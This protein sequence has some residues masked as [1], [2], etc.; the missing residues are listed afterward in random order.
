MKKDIYLKVIL[1]IIAICLVWICMRDI[2]IGPTKL[3]ASQISSMFPQEVVIVGVKFSSYKTPDPLPIKNV[4]PNSLKVEVENF[5][6]IQLVEVV[7]G[8]GEKD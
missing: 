7:G 2:E 4:F 5:P 3:H 6:L 1:T 8:E